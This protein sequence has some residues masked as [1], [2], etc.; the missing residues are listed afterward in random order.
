M[1]A[2]TSLIL[3]GTALS[4]AST[5]AASF[6]C[7]KAGTIV[8]KTICADPALSTLDERMAAAYKTRLKDWDG[9]NAAYV[10]ADQ[11]AYLGL[12]HEI[13][14]PEDSEIDPVCLP[15]PK[16]AF[17]SCLND[18][19]TRRAEELENPDYKLSGVYFR[20]SEDDRDGMILIWPARKAGLDSLRITLKE[21]ERVIG[22]WTTAETNGVVVKGN[23]L[24]AK[25]LPEGMLEKSCTLTLN[26]E[27]DEAEVEA[28]DCGDLDLAG[29]Y[30]RD[31]KDLL[32]HHDLDVDF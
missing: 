18:V 30:E 21:D 13:N 5:S 2:I 17:I 7:A 26:I 28:D 19:M 15:S 27:A 11:R 29:D 3:M 32:V 16:K 4:A 23:T 22:T 6:D 1:R 14:H 8:E 9:D 24:T 12:Y 31:P 20:G 10:K 25:L